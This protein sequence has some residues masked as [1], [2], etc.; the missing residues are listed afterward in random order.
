MHTY[1]HTYTHTHTCIHLP[2]YLPTYLPSYIHTYIHTYRH[3]HTHIHT[4]MQGFV[5]VYMIYNYRPTCTYLLPTYLYTYI[6][7]YLHSYIPTQLHPYIPAYVHTYIPRS[8]LLVSRC[9]ID[10]ELKKQ[11]ALMLKKPQHSLLPFVFPAF[12]SSS[13]Y[14]PNYSKLFK[15][16][17][18]KWFDR[19]LPWSWWCSERYEPP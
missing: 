7:T 9:C 14:F 8:S 2:T 15:D 11:A 18:M 17:M 10:W 6:P 19:V 1:I 16:L 12:L 5:H 4:Y 3:A 13:K